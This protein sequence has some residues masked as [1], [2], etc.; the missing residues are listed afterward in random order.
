MYSFS[1]VHMKMDVLVIKFCMISEILHDKF[2][3]N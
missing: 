3:Q 2:K 1:I